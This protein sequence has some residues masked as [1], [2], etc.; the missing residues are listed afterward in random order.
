MRM[1]GDLIQHIPRRSNGNPAE[2][3][4]LVQTIDK[5]GCDPITSIGFR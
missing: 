5:Q 4:V 3:L 1:V 2:T